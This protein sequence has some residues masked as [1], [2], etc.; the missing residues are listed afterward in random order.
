MH[1]HLENGKQTISIFSQ[2]IKQMISETSSGALLANDCLVHF[3]ISDLPFGGVGEYLYSF[4]CFS[5]SVVKIYQYTGNGFIVL[6]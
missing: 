5:K 2:V 3:T 4:S 1:F 6:L